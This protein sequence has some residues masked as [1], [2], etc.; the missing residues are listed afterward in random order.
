MTHTEISE[1]EERYLFAGDIEDA[2]AIPHSRPP[3]RTKVSPPSNGLL[4]IRQAAQLLGISEKWLY[5]N[6]RTLP[7][8]LIP[9]KTKPRIRFRQADLDVW[10]HKHTIDWR[11]Q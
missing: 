1:L 10:I 6:Y 11:L 2:A 7:H 5:R 3:K 8:V 9:A 4:N